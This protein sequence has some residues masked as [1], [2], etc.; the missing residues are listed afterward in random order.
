MSLSGRL[1][2]L[3]ARVLGATEGSPRARRKADIWGASILGL[4]TLGVI[5]AWLVH[6]RDLVP[7]IVPIVMLGA[8][9]VR[10]SRAT[11]VN[12]GQPPRLARWGGGP[13]RDAEMRTFAGPILDVQEQE[14]NT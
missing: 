14:P 3:D 13:V 4:V 5:G 1:R 10:L 11:G 8:T 6:S 2:R 12:T 9:L 7:L